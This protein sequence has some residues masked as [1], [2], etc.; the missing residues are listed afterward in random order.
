MQGPF[1]VH[2]LCMEGEDLVPA[3]GG[4]FNASKHTKW[5]YDPRT[6]TDCSEPNP[7]SSLFVL[8]H[9]VM[10][11]KFVSQLLVNFMVSWQIKTLF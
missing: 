11:I 10:Q 1:A 4:N 3:I 7:T 5:R 2:V 6:T 9:S 8:H